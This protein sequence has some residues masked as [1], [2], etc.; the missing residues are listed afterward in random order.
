MDA[1]AESWS[2]TRLGITD[3]L[4]ASSD[5]SF[6][7]NQFYGPYNSWERTKGWFA[8]ARQELGS[9][10][11]AAFGYRRHTDDFALFRNDPAAY[12]NNHIDGSWQGSL[13]GT[14]RCTRIP[15]C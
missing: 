15:F 11:V 3:L 9:H 1:S 12:E 14:P 2:G 10:T 13:R 4:V 7:A 8:S 6:G 5:R